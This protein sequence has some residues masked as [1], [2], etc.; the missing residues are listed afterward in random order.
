VHGVGG[1][2]WISR[3][4]QDRSKGGRALP[5][6]SPG[7]QGSKGLSEG[8][9]QERCGSNRTGSAPVFPSPF[10]FSFERSSNE[11]CRG[12]LLVLYYCTGQARPC[13][14][15]PDQS[16]FFSHLCK[17]CSVWRQAKQGI[18]ANAGAKGH[19]NKVA[20]TSKSKSEKEIFGY[21]TAEIPDHRTA[22]LRWSS[23]F[24]LVSNKGLQKE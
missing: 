11:S 14:T 1:I 13:Q 24:S 2:S 10:V 23:L 18:Y 6:N 17:E 8:L 21:R 3:A 7:T 16:H 9:D 20:L 19:Q 5:S 12:T 15:R 4:S 22:R